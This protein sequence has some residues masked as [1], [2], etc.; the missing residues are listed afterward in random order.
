M[1]TTVRDALLGAGA[2][3]RPYNLKE[4]RDLQRALAPEL[5]QSELRYVLASR[6]DGAAG[7]AATGV[8]WWWAFVGVLGESEEQVAPAGD[9]VAARRVEDLVMRFAT[10]L[11]EVRKVNVETVR[12]YVGHVRSWHETAYGEWAS[13]YE[14]R[15]LRR[16]L[17]GMEKVH[18]LP[19]RRPRR[20]VKPQDLKAGMEVKLPLAGLTPLT[21]NLR[22]A[23]SVAFC[24]LLRAAEYSLQPGQSWDAV[25]CLTR[26]DVRFRVVAGRHEAVLMMRPC[27]KLRYYGAKTVPVVLRDGSVLK[28]VTELARMMTSDPV[29]EGERAATPLFRAGTAAVTTT[30]MRGLVKAVVAAMG[31]DPSEYG[32]HSLRIGGATALLAAG[33]QPA[34]IQVMG[35]WDS[36]VYQVYCRWS[37]ATARRMGQAVA[38]T[39]YDDFEGEFTHEELC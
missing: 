7:A 25:Y 18:G 16:L 32:A 37:S 10:W 20:G 22:A 4:Q 12:K 39:T 34:S 9:L 11:L 35:R 14:M 28:P 33:I 26:A 3:R 29:S 24:G 38:S 13:G 30:M 8:R 5:E 31:R 17:Q 19:P 21:A 36:D 6:A 2:R 27:K 23:L 15:M 1:R